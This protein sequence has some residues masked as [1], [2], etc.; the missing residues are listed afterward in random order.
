MATYSIVAFIRPPSLVPTGV[1]AAMGCT[2]VVGSAA[3]AL[4]VAEET[5]IFHPSVVSSLTGFVACA[6]SAA[7]GLRYFW[8]SSKG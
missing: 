8:Q 3:W 6:L 4:Q 1:T 5:V 2:L 7:L